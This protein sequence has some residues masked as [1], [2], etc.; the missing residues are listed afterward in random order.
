MSTTAM[1]SNPRFGIIFWLYLLSA[2]IFILSH[3]TFV[4]LTVSNSILI[5]DDTF[6]FQNSH[7]RSWF[8]SES[9]Q[10]TLPQQ[11]QQPNCP[12]MRQIQGQYAHHFNISLNFYLHSP[13]NS[14][15]EVKRNAMEFHNLQQLLI[16]LDQILQMEHYDFINLTN[17][18]RVV[19][20]N[21]FIV[22]HVVDLLENELITSPK[23]GLTYVFI[24]QSAA[25]S[26]QQ[27]L[28]TLSF[29]HKSTSDVLSHDSNGYWLFIIH[30]TRSEFI[31]TQ[32]YKES[33]DTFGIL[34]LQ[35]D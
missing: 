11:Q 26:S 16:S 22:D 1:T 33:I 2:L 34:S 28:S 23:L 14:S 31:K 12:S 6:Q 24:F 20:V 8:T 29:L 19:F 32:Q 3:T 15:V 5:P 21:I 13:T 27:T 18:S 4:L 9:E 10:L 30:T 17:T 35:S 25:D 7:D